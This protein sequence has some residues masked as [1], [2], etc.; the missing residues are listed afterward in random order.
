MGRL[1]VDTRLPIGFF[2][3][4]SFPSRKPVCSSRR[5]V[6]HADHATRRAGRLNRRETGH[7]IPCSC[8]MARSRRWVT[9]DVSARPGREH[10]DPLRRACPVA[11]RGERLAPRYARGPQRQ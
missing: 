8:V 4:D 2:L 5:N 1:Q 10:R 3:T 9:D 6:V 7:H 11:T